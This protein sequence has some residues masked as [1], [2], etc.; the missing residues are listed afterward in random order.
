MKTISA[1][2]RSAPTVAPDIED[3]GIVHAGN[4][5]ETGDNVIVEHSAVLHSRK[6]RNNLSIGKFALS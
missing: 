1:R 5:M 6:E 3:N 4:D 2:T